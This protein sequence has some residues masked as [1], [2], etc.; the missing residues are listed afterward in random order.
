[1]LL[2]AN[3]FFKHFFK[4]GTVH[5]RVHEREIDGDS[6]IERDLRDTATRCNV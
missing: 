6:Q 2:M 1:M 3:F 5:K 4:R